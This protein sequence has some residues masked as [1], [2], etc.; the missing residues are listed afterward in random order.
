MDLW[1]VLNAPRKAASK[2]L[3]AS[4][5][6]KS[7]CVPMS[8]KSK[9]LRRGERF[10]DPQYEPYTTVIGQFVLTWNDLHEKLALIFGATLSHL[11]RKK[12]P[13]KY[14]SDYAL[15]EVERFAG[16][17]SSSQYDRP[18]RDMLRGILI[19]L[20]VD[21]LIE[22]HEFEKDVQ[23]LL[24]QTDK[25]EDFR[26]TAVHSPLIHRFNEYDISPLH[27]SSRERRKYDKV[28]R[29]LNDSHIEIAP[30]VLMRNRRAL[31]VAQK[32]ANDAFL[33]EMRWARDATAV[34]RDFALRIF[35][36]LEY[37]PAPW[38]RRPSLPNLGQRMTRP[39][40]RRPAPAK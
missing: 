16:I 18:K 32:E 10:T 21:D 17:W 39:N 22:F 2:R 4:C 34:L 25:L 7:F 15:R 27:M 36:A 28:R 35:W 31:R 30:N 26:N 37:E 8:R 6:V 19:P 5:L 40:R 14:R 20:V 13:Q 23:W 11:D 12:I 24:D 3:S 9:E 1:G 38:P 33:R 29:Y